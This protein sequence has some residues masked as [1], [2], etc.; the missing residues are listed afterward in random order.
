MRW[1]CPQLPPARRLPITGSLTALLAVLALSGCA[2]IMHGTT[3]QIGVSSAPTGARVVVD[4]NQRGITPIVLDLER[5]RIHSISVQADGYQPFEMALTRSTSGW[6]WGNI[7]FGGL[8][9]LAVDAATGGLYKLSPETVSAELQRSGVEWSD[10]EGA[11]FVRL[12]SAQDVSAE[13]IGTLVRE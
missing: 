10:D 13:R 11:L 7:V 8:I 4:G 1:P 9:G 2:S 6:V 3:Q 5:K 12:L